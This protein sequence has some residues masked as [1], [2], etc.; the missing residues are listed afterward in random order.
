MKYILHGDKI[1][2]HPVESHSTTDVL[3]LL[4]GTFYLCPIVKIGA[5]G[6]KYSKRT[7]NNNLIRFITKSKRRTLLNTMKDQNCIADT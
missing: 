2:A 7:R 3:K 4:I 1:K 6:A 5:E